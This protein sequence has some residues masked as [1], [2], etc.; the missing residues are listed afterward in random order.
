M[1]SLDLY[2]LP[3]D[4]QSQKRHRT[5]K[6][7]NTYDPSHADKTKVSL[8]LLAQR[9]LKRGIIS[10]GPLKVEIGAYY[11]IPK[12]FSEK[13]KERMLNTYKQTIPDVDNIAK[14]YLDAMNKTIIS[15]DNIISELVV[16]KIWDSD[17]H[18][19]IKIKSL[20]D[21][22]NYKDLGW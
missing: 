22:K 1:I 11:S 6:F 8:E 19:T 12:S 17:P 21:T 3:G 20:G 15:D 9:P 14:F 16:K 7:R 18:V 5:G 2:L 10:E 13:K 4:P